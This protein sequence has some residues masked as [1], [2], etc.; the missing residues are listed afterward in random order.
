MTVAP[1]NG[2]SMELESD[3]EM[4]PSSSSIGRVGGVDARP[5]PAGEEARKALLRLICFLS[6]S[7]SFPFYAAVIGFSPHF[8]PFVRCGLDYIA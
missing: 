4:L 6:F 1:L 2:N 7:L 3:D 8:F 5:S